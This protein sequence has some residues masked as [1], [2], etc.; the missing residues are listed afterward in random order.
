MSRRFVLL[1]L[2]ALGTAT[3]VGSLAAAAP[4]GA[5][6]EFPANAG[7]A[8]FRIAS[9]ADGNLWFSDQGAGQKAIGRI[10]TSGVISEFG[11]PAAAV[12]RQV[13]VGADGNLWFTDTN[14]AAPGIG[15]IT[16]S[17]TMTVFP[18]EAGSFPNAL[19]LG[20]DGNLWFTDKG[21]NPTLT[22]LPAIGRITPDGTITKFRVGL[23]AGTSPNGITPAAD[24]FL[25]FTDQGSPKAIGRIKTSGTPAEI[26]TIQEFSTGLGPNANPA[27][28]TTAGDGTLWFT[29]QSTVV[30]S[31][32]IGRVAPD[33]SITESSVGLLAGSQPSE[34]TPGA[35]GKLWFGEQAS[36]AGALGEIAMSGATWTITN[37]ALP[38]GIVPGAIRTGPDG[39]IWFLDNH[40]GAQEIAQFGVGAPAAS[41][42]I[43][44][45]GAGHFGVPQ[46]CQDTWNDWAGAQPSRTALGFDGYQWLLDGNAIA[47]QTAQSYT[48]RPGDAGHELSCKATVTYTLFP[49]T[50]SATS[51][52]VHVKTAA[53]LLDLLAAQIQ[54]FNLEHGLAHDLANKARHAAN[55]LA[56][57]KQ[58]EACHTLDEFAQRVAD[59]WGHDKSKLTLA[60]TKELLFEVYAIEISDAGCL[61]SASTLPAAEAAVADLIEAINGV[62][63]NG[64]AN[65]LRHNAAEI[66][67]QAARGDGNPC[68]KLAK[69]EKKITDAVP[70]KL[71]AAEAA[72]LT[73]AANAVGVNL[74]C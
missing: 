29:D 15:R 63:D 32:A 74:G 60:Q 36:P 20:A 68:K 9:G 47:G 13:R 3:V 34:V 67:K 16:A 39:N 41:S 49:T 18:L 1:T 28:I 69:L 64:W 10:T 48:L 12:P 71:S 43:A 14:P 57:G 54:S 59:E 46:V 38:A 52:A 53:E 2:L 56:D 44:I 40:I 66:G 24:G 7:S 5:L 26:G 70:K 51:P 73:T 62:A 55:K 4:L 21:K 31:R 17:G 65:D 30:A 19:A 33:G 58:S 37:H 42:G 23:N 50:V 27:A 61:S 25:W 45:A 8:P 35:D 22:T 11:L 72:T 6:T